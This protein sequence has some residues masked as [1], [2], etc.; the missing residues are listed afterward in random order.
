MRYYVL[1]LKNVHEDKL[2]KYNS[3]TN[4]TKKIISGDVIIK[5]YKNDLYRYKLIDNDRDCMIENY[6]D[7]LTLAVTD[8]YE[9]KIERVFQIPYENT[10][11]ELTVKK[12]FIGPKTCFVTE[13]RGGVVVDFYFESKEEYDS[14]SLKEDLASFLSG[15][16]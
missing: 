3:I 7:S 12:Y 6:I 4:K 13:Y 2:K 10:I 14:F 5:Q 15:V 9:K 16:M 1:E 8:F 11:I